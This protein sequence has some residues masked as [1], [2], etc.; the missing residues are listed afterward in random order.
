MKDAPYKSYSENGIEL[1]D[2]RQEVW[3]NINRRG[4]KA[5]LGLLQKVD[6]NVEIVLDL[7]KKLLQ[8]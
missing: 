7:I 1:Q 2:F 5:K 3:N 8:K 6:S 4:E